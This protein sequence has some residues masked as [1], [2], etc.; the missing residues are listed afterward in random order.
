MIFLISMQI[1]GLSI[2]CFSIHRGVNPAIPGVVLKSDYDT[3]EW[4]ISNKPDFWKAKPNTT[5]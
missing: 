2:N 3:L 5:S 4:I 1:F